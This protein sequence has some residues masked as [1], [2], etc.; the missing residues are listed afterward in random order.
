[1]SWVPTLLPRPAPA[2]AWHTGACPRAGPGCPSPHLLRGLP[3]AVTHGLHVALLFLQLL[4]KLCAIRASRR[5]FSSCSAF[6]RGKAAAWDLQP[7][8][9]R[10]L[11]PLE[12][13]ASG[14]PLLQS[15]EA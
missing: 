3:D 4:L 12:G 10:Q 13:N 1:M 7:P 14:R 8:W 6:L 15:R 2:W 11:P 9:L 5:R